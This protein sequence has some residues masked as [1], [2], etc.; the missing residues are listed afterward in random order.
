[1]F[2]FQEVE[3]EV[4]DFEK[5]RINLNLSLTNLSINRIQIM[6]N[7]FGFDNYWGVTL[8]LLF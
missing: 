6:F 5:I 4:E 7:S 8:N 3:V 1:M 2:S